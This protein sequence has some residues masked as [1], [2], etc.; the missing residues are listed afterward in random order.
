[1]RHFIYEFVR[2]SSKDAGD[3]DLLGMH[4]HALLHVQDVHDHGQPEAQALGPG[5][6]DL[7][8]CFFACS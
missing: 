7:A 8:D 5:K 4:K 6:H 3:Q 1:M 2:N